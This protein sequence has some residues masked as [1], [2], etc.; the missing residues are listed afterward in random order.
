MGFHLEI[1]IRVAEI[2]GVY[3]FHNYFFKWSTLLLRYFARLACFTAE[4]HI[5]VHINIFSNLMGNI[6]DLSRI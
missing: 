2:V 5:C 3:I 4:D 1:S 6:R